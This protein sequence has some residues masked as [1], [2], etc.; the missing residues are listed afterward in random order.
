MGERRFTIVRSVKLTK[1]K[2][3]TAI[4]Q[5]Q[6]EL[7]TVGAIMEIIKSVNN[8]FSEHRVG[9]DLGND[10]IQYK[11]ANMEEI[12]YDLENNAGE[13]VNSKRISFIF[14]NGNKLSEDDFKDI[15]VEIFTNVISEFDN[16]KVDINFVNSDT[17]KMEH[18]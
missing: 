13:A 17:I 3:V 9:L 5:L 16:I 6:A 15:I 1:G 8:S 12:G 2:G 10:I 4:V 11:T 7:C 18:K 14:T